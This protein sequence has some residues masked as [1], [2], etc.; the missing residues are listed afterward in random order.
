MILGRC[1]ARGVP[2]ERVGDC[3]GLPATSVVLALARQEREQRLMQQQQPP[4]ATVGTDTNVE[5][6]DSGAIKLKGPEMSRGSHVNV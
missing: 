1:P 4:S 2:P 3:G 6:A 5:T